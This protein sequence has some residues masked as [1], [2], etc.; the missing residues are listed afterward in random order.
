LVL[1][2]IRSLPLVALIKLPEIGSY[3]DRSHAVVAMAQA[4]KRS[5]DDILEANTL[6]CSQ[7]KHAPELI[8][9]WL[10]T[11]QSAPDNGRYS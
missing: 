7:Q 11:D 3:K 2:L 6:I 10:L 9:D 1:T 5:F 4:P 8:L